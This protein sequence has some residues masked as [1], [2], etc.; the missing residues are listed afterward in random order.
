MEL[1]QKARFPPVEPFRVE[2]IREPESL[3]VEVV[4]ELVEKGAKEGLELDDLRSMRRAHPQRDPEAAFLIRLVETMKLA[5]L[6]GGSSLRHTHAKSRNAEGRGESV[7]QGLGR[8][9][10][11]NGVS[12][13][14]GPRES[15]DPLAV[16]LRSMERDLSDGVAFVVDFLLARGEPLVVGKAQFRLRPRARSRATGGR[17]SPLRFRASSR[18][19]ARRASSRGR[20]HDLPREWGNQRG[21]NRGPSGDSRR[22]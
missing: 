2:R 19:E 16:G 14:E 10:R 7:H 20:P 8:E 12:A 4:A 5:R 6:P 22:S 11:R 17:R 21:R 15:F 1:P 9:L 3:V 13:R 18:R